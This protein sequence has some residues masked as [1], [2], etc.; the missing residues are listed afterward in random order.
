MGRPFVNKRPLGPFV[1]QSNSHSTGATIKFILSGTSASANLIG[2]IGDI[3]ATTD[4]VNEV[5]FNQA[6]K[7]EDVTVKRQPPNTEVKIEMLR[8]ENYS[9]INELINKMEERYEVDGVII[10]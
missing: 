8:A 7:P 5:L 2:G 3:N 1:Q 6:I 4:V 10:S 9:T